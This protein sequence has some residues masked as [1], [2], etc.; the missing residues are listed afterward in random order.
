[1]EG[2]NRE[3]ANENIQSMLKM[4]AEK[5]NDGQTSFAAGMRFAMTHLNLASD[6][7]IHFVL[8]GKTVGKKRKYKKRK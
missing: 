5:V 2:C 1:M 3:I 7:E 8:T 6:E 4:Y